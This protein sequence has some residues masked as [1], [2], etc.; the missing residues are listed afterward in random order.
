[1]KVILFTILLT[2]H[3]GCLVRDASV[4]PLFHVQQTPVPLLVLTLLMLAVLSGKCLDL[5]LWIHFQNLNLDIEVLLYSNNF[6][7]LAQ[8]PWFVDAQ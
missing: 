8:G 2:F 6:S 4:G 3:A 5:L 1:M 7:L